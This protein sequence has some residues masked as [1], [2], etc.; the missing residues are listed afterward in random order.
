[1]KRIAVVGAGASGMSAA[2][3]A[4]RAGAHVTL[5]ERNPR[6]GKKLSQTG[7]GRCNFGNRNLSGQAYYSQSPAFIEAFIKRFDT[8]DTIRF[9]ESLGLVIQERDG[10]LYPY[11]AQA[12]T[13]VEVLTQELVKLGVEL[14][15][16][17]FIRRVDRIT[18]NHPRFCI[19]VY[20]DGQEQLYYFDRL[21]L[22]CGGLAAPKTGSDG[23]GYTLCET[24]GHPTTPTHPALVPLLCT[25]AYCKEL[26][27]VRA[28]ARVHIL[29]EDRE[30]AQEEGELQFTKEGLSGIPI[31]QI[32]RI[33]S[34]RLLQ[35]NGKTKLT[36]SVNF[37]PELP[38]QEMRQWIDRRVEALGERD[39]PTFFQGFLHQKVT[40]LLCQL[41]Q[42]APKS[43]ADDAKSRIQL[44]SNRNH[45]IQSA[46]VEHGHYVQYMKIAQALPFHIRATASFEQAQVTAGGIPLQ[47]ITEEFESRIH[48]GLFLV[49]E[50][51]D[52]DGICG[53]YNL[54][55]AWG[56][57]QIAGNAA[58]GK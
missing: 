2:I 23:S 24:L 21:I 45:M 12:S 52:A 37:F 18:I 56:S 7:N 25:D 40:N 43:H 15:T 3:A 46:T 42:K 5:F 17:S 28:H 4:A 41:S 53:G 14:H 33:I 31:F 11:S 13:V 10:L 36:A 48:S 34:E 58:A 8:A 35:T 54:H 32:S 27:G 55:W 47:D 19:T 51:L 9:F 1:M 20:S 57:G 16:G 50:L 29:E 49:G 26:A 39:V 22:A 38:P 44:S 6:V 30:L